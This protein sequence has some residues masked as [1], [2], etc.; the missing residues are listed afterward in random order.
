MQ[1]NGS[2]VPPAIAQ[3]PHLLS[4]S[5]RGKTEALMSINAGGRGGG[6]AGGVFS[7][8]ERALTLRMAF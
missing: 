8:A 6:E 7:L 3:A 4:R 2:L 1:I 5:S